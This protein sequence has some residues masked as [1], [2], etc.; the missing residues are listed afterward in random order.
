MWVA[1]VQIVETI[2]SRGKP[3]SRLSRVPQSTNKRGN[4]YFDD[5]SLGLYVRFPMMSCCGG[6][7]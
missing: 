5:V 6:S 1:G 3:Q 7:N 4:V 2:H